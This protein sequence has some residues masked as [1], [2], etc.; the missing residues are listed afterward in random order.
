MY[1]Q[2]R[3]KNTFKTE[4]FSRLLTSETMKL[5]ES[6]NSKITKYR[7]WWKYVLSGDYRSN[8]SSL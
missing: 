8:I 5:F 7:K 1:K 3:K 4:Y 2:N 6:T